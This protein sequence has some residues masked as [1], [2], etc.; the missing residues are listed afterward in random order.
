MAIDD[1]L[2]Y[3][4]YARNENLAMELSVDEH[5]MGC[6]TGDENQTKIRRFHRFLSFYSLQSLFIPSKAVG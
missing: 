4:E 2:L 5:A 3:C 6:T 1:F